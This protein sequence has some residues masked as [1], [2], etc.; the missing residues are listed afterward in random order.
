MTISSCDIIEVFSP[1]IAYVGCTLRIKKNGND[2]I[3]KISKYIF[4]IVSLMNCVAIY[5]SLNHH[6]NIF[7]YTTEHGL[8][9][10]SFLYISY[11]LIKKRLALLF[12]G[13]GGTFMAILFFQIKSFDS[14]H[15]I[16][17]VLSAWFSYSLILCGL[18]IFTFLAKGENNIKSGYKN[19]STWFAGAVILYFVSIFLIYMSFDYLQFISQDF[20]SILWKAG[21]YAL[22]IFFIL[23]FIAFTR[24]E[25]DFLTE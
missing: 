24:S 1:W 21:T 9:L 13:C 22:L 25:Q 8:I 11:L 6:N 4:I 7:I 16:N 2:I 19:F 5:K 23:I 20:F 14:Y 15:S 17:P 3:I 12:L 10:F 18:I